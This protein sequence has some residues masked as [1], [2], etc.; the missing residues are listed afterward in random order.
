MNWQYR[1][2]ADVWLICLSNRASKRRP[3]EK[4]PERVKPQVSDE[5]DEDEKVRSCFFNSSVFH[6]IPLAGISYSD[7]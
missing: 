3:E 4:E 6:N 5:K 2:Q 7:F 1:F